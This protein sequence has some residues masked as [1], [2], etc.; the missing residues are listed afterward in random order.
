MGADVYTFISLSSFMV[1]SPFPHIRLS[2]SH[3]VMHIQLGYVHDRTGPK[4]A[5]QAVSRPCPPKRTA[6]ACSAPLPGSRRNPA[7]RASHAFSNLRYSS[8]LRYQ[9]NIL[10]QGAL[11]RFAS[12][13]AN[14][15]RVKHNLCAGAVR[16][17]ADTRP[18]TQCARLAVYAFRRAI[19]SIL[20][21]L[22]AKT[23]AQVPGWSA[24]GGHRT[25]LR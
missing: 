23:A 2:R 8:S 16:R 12:E 7:G 20:P 6:E 1:S 24:T 22:T 9:S 11:G 17:I 10:H 5:E 18:R 14:A 13:C 15:Y 3:G 19:C 25:L 21:I 4:T